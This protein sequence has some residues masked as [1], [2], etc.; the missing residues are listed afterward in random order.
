M[1]EPFS[2]RRRLLAFTGACPL[3]PPPLVLT[4]IVRG[5]HL[6]LSAVKPMPR[7]RCQSCGFEVKASEH[8]TC[9]QCLV[10]MRPVTLGA[11]MTATP[12]LTGEDARVGGMMRSNRG[13][14][15]R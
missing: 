12:L 1:R 7:Y 14:V 15:E 3:L 13:M 5:R 2:P 9:P 11:P 4:P 6:N 8:V 10:A